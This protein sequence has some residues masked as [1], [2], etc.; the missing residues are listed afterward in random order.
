MGAFFAV[1]G[2]AILGV[3]S[4]IMHVIPTDISGGRCYYFGQL[5]P[6][7]VCISGSVYLS[8]V[9]IGMVLFI[10]G[11]VKILRRKKKGPLAGSS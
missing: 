10:A 2:A 7:T 11:V 4:F 3:A 8:A 9:A 5:N 6:N 1:L